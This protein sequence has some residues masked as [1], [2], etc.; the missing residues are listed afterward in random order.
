M[1]GSSDNEHLPHIFLNFVFTKFTEFLHVN[2]AI[3]LAR[4]TRYSHKNLIGTLSYKKIVRAHKIISTKPK[5]KIKRV[6]IRSKNDLLEL[7]ESCQW[8]NVEHLT[9][10]ENFNEKIEEYPPNVKGIIFGSDYEQVTENLPAGLKNKRN[11]RF[12]LFR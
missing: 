2:E 7:K 12:L 6:A 3:K 9:F 8:K 4:L 5:L 11:R 1:S 10:S